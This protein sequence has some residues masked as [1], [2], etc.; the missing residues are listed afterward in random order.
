M[1]LEKLGEVREAY[2]ECKQLKE[3]IVELE[4]KRISPRGAVY[5][6]ERVQTSM[7]GDIQPEGIAEVESLL[8]LYN[9]KL[10]ESCNLI[11]EFENSLEKLSARERRLMRYYYIDCMTWEQ[12]CVE[13]HLSWTNLHRVRKEAQRKITEE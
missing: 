12:I 6:S 9:E 4:H 11:Q 7:K 13:M 2:K 8:K 10:K 5:G 3:R 1:E